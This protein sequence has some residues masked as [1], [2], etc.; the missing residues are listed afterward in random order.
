MLSVPHLIIIFLVALVVL[1][2][3]KLPEVARTL[4][5]V[6]S[7]F[8][9]VTTDFRSTLENEMNEIDRQ[10][11]EKERLAREAAASVPAPPVAALPEAVPATASVAVAQEPAETA[12]EAP[13]AVTDAETV[14]LAT[15]E[16]PLET[17]VEKHVE[18]ASG[19]AAEEPAP[20]GESHPA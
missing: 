2:P 3:E 18:A 9:K 7:E 17:A 11:R 12:T 19:P 20:N 5:K 1:G 6:M 13:R 15:A 16:A 14:S 10:A 4:G 8:R